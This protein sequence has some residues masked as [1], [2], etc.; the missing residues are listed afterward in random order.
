MLNYLLGEALV[1]N[2]DQ[3]QAKFYFTRALEK[4][5]DFHRARLMIAN[6]YF[7]DMDFLIAANEVQRVLDS[8][9]QNYEANILLGKIET[10]QHEYFKAEKRFSQ[11]IELA[12]ERPAAYYRLGIVKRFLKQPVQALE[13]FET[14][15]NLHPYFMDAFTGLISVQIYLKQYD[16]AMERCDEHLKKISDNIVA[17]AMILNHK[18]NLL[19]IKQKIN[20]AKMEFK[21]A[22]EKNPEF[23]DPY[24]SLARILNSENKINEA[25]HVYEELAVKRPDLPA[26]YSLLGSMYEK[27][28]K[29]EL[30]EELY[31]KALKVNKDFIPAMNNLA[32]LYAEQ[33]KEL[34]KALDLARD[35]KKRL[36]NSPAVIDTLGWVYFKKEL[37][38][39]AK[40]EFE[41]C[42]AYAPENPVYH[43]HLGLVYNK[44]GEYIQAEKT[45]K[46]ALELQNDFKGSEYARTILKGLNIPKQL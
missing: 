33:N 6:L 20:P 16:R 2:K 7:L 11:M 26:P 14:A 8:K 36:M 10:A 41:E 34:N 27:Q 45:L 30:A 40:E 31:K 5:P 12:P 25:I 9:P 24:L 43:Y 22:I 17:S 39:S 32:F 4:N 37:Y 19:L 15:I 38:D 42:I 18:G 29:Y 13:N 44:K 28:G 21:A 23:V 3:D 35:A 46:K 1:N